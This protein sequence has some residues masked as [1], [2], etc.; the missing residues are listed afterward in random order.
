MTD[1]DKIQKR[2][3]IYNR[4]Q[5][6]RE[7]GGEP[8]FAD[9]YWRYVPWDLRLQGIFLTLIGLGVVALVITEYFK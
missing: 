9:Q 6:I 5:G 8:S 3:P 2:V 7:A 4:N 1:T